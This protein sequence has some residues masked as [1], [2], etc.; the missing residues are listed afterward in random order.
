MQG[1]FRFFPSHF[2]SMLHYL[3]LLLLLLLFCCCCCLHIKNH[4]GLSI[5][6]LLLSQSLRTNPALDSANF[7]GHRLTC[8]HSFILCNDN[9]VP[10][11]LCPYSPQYNNNQPLPNSAY[12]LALH[13]NIVVVVVVVVVVVFTLKT[14]PI[15]LYP[16]P[17]YVRTDPTLDALFS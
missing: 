8:I 9:A 1:P 7:R 13:V 6:Y 17:S 3:L 15:S 14:V 2:F 16:V 4:P 10:C 12:N 5:Q 11:I